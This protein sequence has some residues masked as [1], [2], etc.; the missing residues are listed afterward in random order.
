MLTSL[1]WRPE[2][3]A[4]IQRHRLRLEQGASETNIKRGVGGTLDIEF[5][6][7]ML[8]LRAARSQPEVLVPGTLEALARLRAAGLIGSAH[9]DALE[10]NYRWL[11]RVESGLRL[12][13]LPARHDLPSAND[14][15]DQLQFLLQTHAVGAAAAGTTD[16]SSTIHPLS[17]TCAHIRQANR[18]IFSAVFA[19]AMRE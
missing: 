16:S 6:V 18:E 14:E 3:A 4:D 9:A 19:E 15:L 7:Q 11:R 10:A 12:M 5:I 13:N 1:E 8:Q 17:A 2:Y